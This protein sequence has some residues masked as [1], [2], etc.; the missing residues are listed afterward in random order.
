[1][2]IPC[3]HEDNK[4]NSLLKPFSPAPKAHHTDRTPRYINI[5]LKSNMCIIVEELIKKIL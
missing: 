5:F 4:D 3:M 2:V 1:M